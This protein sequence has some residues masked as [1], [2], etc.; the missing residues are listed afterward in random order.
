ML[1]ALNT[2]VFYI[3][4]LDY[5]RSQSFRS[6]QTIIGRAGDTIYHSKI[7]QIY[8]STGVFK[9]LLIY[10]TFAIT[11]KLYMFYGFSKLMSSWL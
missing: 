8:F 5:C 9:N 6:F 3:F 1:D 7:F 4:F 11:L 10:L 2:F